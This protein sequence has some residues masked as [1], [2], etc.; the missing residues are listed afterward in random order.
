MG[1]QNNQP[2]EEQD[3]IEVYTTSDG[4]IA[5]PAKIGFKRDEI[6][7]IYGEQLN[8]FKKKPKEPYEQPEYGVAKF[9]VPIT[10]KVMANQYGQLKRLVQDVENIK[11]G[12]DDANITLHEIENEVQT[13]Q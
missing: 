12:L 13:L 5:L 6:E 11:K 3:V 4:S 10:W 7:K 9:M 2:E 8:R 1:A